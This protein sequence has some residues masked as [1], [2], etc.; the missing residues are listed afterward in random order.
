[1][2]VAIIPALPAV[3]AGALADDDFVPCALATSVLFVDK[4]L[5][6]EPNAEAVLPF[7]ANAVAV[8]EEESAAAIAVEPALL[9]YVADADVVAAVDA[10]VPAEA[11]VIALSGEIPG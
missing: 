1:L 6:L 7:A 8:V 4:F 3:E 2:P 11:G 9:V 5:V 10:A